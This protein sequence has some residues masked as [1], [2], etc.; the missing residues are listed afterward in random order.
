MIKLFI[1]IV[2]LLMNKFS[3]KEKIN[4]ININTNSDTKSTNYIFIFSMTKLT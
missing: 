3:K 1:N 2:K 4:V